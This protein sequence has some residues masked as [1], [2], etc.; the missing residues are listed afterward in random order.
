MRRNACAPH[1]PR[2]WRLKPPKAPTP[3][4]PK[5]FCALLLKKALL[6]SSDRGFA[7]L[8]VLWAAVFLAFLMTQILATSRTALNLAENLRAAA[9]A[10]AA[11]DGAIQEAIFHAL[12]TDWPADRQPH[13]LAIG[14]I[15]VT[16]TVKSLAG[17]VNP[18]TAS[19][20]L[21]AGLLRA[22]GA[23]ADAAAGIASNIILWREPAPSP[24]AGAALLQQYRAAGLVYGP[25]GRPFLEIGQLSNVLGMNPALL[26]A[27]KPHLSLFQTGD[28]NIGQADP[29]VRQAISYA[30]AVGPAFSGGAGAPSVTI[31][32]CAAGPAPL[33]R[34]A[35]VGLSGLASLPPFTI[36]QR[37][38]GQ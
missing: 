18:N 22:A 34:H 8:I 36:E 35:V 16:V 13:A 4:E 6:S 19:L 28:P 27:L 38:D 14:G 32:A 12:A 5:V 29:V 23:P 24:Q 30:S 7:L 1:P 3:A 17:M 31:T 37:A 33:C 10:R 25:A 11:D 21:L 26:A 15:A 20:P 2:R 9:Q